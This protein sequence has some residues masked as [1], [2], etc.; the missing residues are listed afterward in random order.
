MK[1]E[2]PAND[3]KGGV[4][5]LT[6]GEAGIGIEF[7]FKGSAIGTGQEMIGLDDNPIQPTPIC[8]LSLKPNLVHTIATHSKQLRP[9]AW[10]HHC[11]ITAPSLYHHWCHHWYH[12]CTITGAITVGET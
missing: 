1:S 7:T 8:L 9:H 5:A 3:A 4:Q 12:H 10:Y 6:L 11:T 2:T